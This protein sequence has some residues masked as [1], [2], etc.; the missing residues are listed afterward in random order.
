MSYGVSPA[1]QTAVY[2][3]L[4]T[5]TALAAMVGPAVFDALPAGALPSL[6]VALGPEVVRDRSDQS[7]AG[8]EHQFTISV[9]TDGAGFVA[10][11]AAAAAV[12]D[13]LVDAPLLLGRGRLVSLN[14]YKAAAVRVGGGMTRRIELTFR[15]RVE[16]DHSA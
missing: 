13:A 15:A 9:V 5:D 14:F 2:Q 3:K 1:L 12:S 4:M 6:Y 8:A 7:G 16:D 11:K 10:A